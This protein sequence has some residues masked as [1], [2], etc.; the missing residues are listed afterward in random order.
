M[1]RYTVWPENSRWPQYLPYPQPIGKPVGSVPNR[2]A[3][4]W[5]QAQFAPSFLPQGSASVQTFSYKPNYRTLYGV[6]G[7]VYQT[8]TPRNEYGCATCGGQAK[9]NPSIVVDPQSFV[10]GALTGAVAL[11]MFLNRK[12]A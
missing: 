7:N 10:L 4:D 11:Y 5:P 3:I 12:E 1:T 9:T 8:Q 2:T 6:G